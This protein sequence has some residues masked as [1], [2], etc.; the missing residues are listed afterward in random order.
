MWADFGKFFRFKM[1]WKQDISLIGAIFVLFEI[2]L[3]L[4]KEF[5]KKIRLSEG[6]SN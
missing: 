3:F 6:T 1:I 2:A 4:T 5:Y